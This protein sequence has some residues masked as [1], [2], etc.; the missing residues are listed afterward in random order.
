ME[1]AQHQPV[2]AR[3]GAASG[4]NVSGLRRSAVV[5]SSLSANH[6][7]CKPERQTTWKAV[8]P[9]FSAE[10]HGPLQEPEL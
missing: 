5:W 3:A 7:S 8:C 9:G 4:C 2:D 10:R 1:L 6:G